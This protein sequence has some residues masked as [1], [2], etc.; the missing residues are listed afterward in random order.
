MGEKYI[1]GHENLSLSQIFQMLSEISGVP[2]P[3]VRLPYWPVL[4]LAYLNEFWATRLSHRPPRMPVTAIRMAKK[5]LYFDTQT[6]VK[7]LGFTLTPV[8]QALADAVTW[9]REQGYA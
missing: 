9:F 4:A 1:L 3:K 8:R 5:Y 6:A 7:Y 2:A